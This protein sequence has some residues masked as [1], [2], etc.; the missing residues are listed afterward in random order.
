[1]KPLPWTEPVWTYL[2]Y[3]EHGLFVA[4]N[5]KGVHG[6]LTANYWLVPGTE[7]EIEK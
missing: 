6:T 5:P 7:K 2:D 3:T 1:M 4:A